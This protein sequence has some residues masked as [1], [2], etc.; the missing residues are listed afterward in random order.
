MNKKPK[1]NTFS[2]FVSIPHSKVK[3]PPEA[4]WLKEISPSVLMCDVDAFV[5]DLYR[6][7]LGEFQ[8]PSVVFEWHRYAVDAN[9]FSTDISLATVE[10][11][12]ELVP[13]KSVSDIHWHKTTRGDLLIKEPLSSTLHKELIK[14]YFDPFHV[15]MKKQIAD[16][17]KAGSQSI[18]LLDLHSMPSQGL[19]FHRDPG[20]NRPQVVVGD[21]EGQ[22]SSRVF[23]DLVVKA[24]QQ[25]GFETA[26]NW[27]YRGGAITQRYGHPQKG[28][29]ALQVELNRK[30]YMDEKSKNKIPQYEQIQNQLKQA[31]SYV[32]EKPS[33][34]LYR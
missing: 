15:R 32:V 30:L 31:L 17:K 21:Q 3:I 25:A 9:R 10:E 29:E 20:K 1:K 19:D 27:P 24:Y 34:I 28:Q 14:K 6:P 7:A 13:G 12:K 8:I 26:L 2:L 11:A 4:D 33:N 18:Y 23:R 5:D 16:F 22:S